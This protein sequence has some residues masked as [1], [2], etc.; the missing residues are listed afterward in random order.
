MKTG[1]ISADPRKV[2][3]KTYF[4]HGIWR[5]CRVSCEPPPWWLPPIKPVTAEWQV[6]YVWEPDSHDWA[7]L[8]YNPD[9]FL[10]SSEHTGCPNGW[11]DGFARFYAYDISFYTYDGWTAEKRNNGCVCEVS[12]TSCSCS[13][14]VE[15][16]HDYIWYGSRLLVG[17][18]EPRPPTKVTIWRSSNGELPNYNPWD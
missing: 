10:P 14:F 8:D 9:D 4:Y 15:Q 11:P 7:Y 6:V 3:W 5:R 13:H 12:H 17:L 16:G 2:C 18:Y 1:I